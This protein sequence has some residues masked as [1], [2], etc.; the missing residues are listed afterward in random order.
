[1]AAL[2][3]TLVRKLRSGSRKQSFPIANAVTLY[4]G[5][6]VAIN[7]SGYVT[8]YAGA[9]IDTSRAA[10]IVGFVQPHP[11]PADLDQSLKGDTALTPVP[12]ATVETA[13]HILEQVA[14]TGVTAQSDVGKLV[15]LNSN[16]NDLTLTR[17]QNALALGVIDRWH[18]STTSDV[19][20]FSYET[21]LAL[22]KGMEAGGLQYSNTADSAAVTNTTTETAF[23]KSVTLA[24]VQLATGDV[25]EIVCMGVATATNST[26]TLNVKLKV[27]TEIVASTG[28][29]DVANDDIFYLHA[30]V[31]VQASGASGAL[32]A[33]GVRAIGADNTVT[34]KP[35][36]TDQASED[37]SGNVLVSATATWSVA[38]AGNSCKLEIL[39]VI[40]HRTAI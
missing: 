1:M 2:T 5:S 13:E 34:A 10:V 9:A 19:R 33:T 27:G 12:E 36:R 29:V 14:V 39:D 38:N 32:M 17:P 11:Y 35:F 3:A 6:Y 40:K 7:T 16:D 4:Q 30:F 28:A 37:L 21:R 23:D 25:L 26:D 20:V 18:T 8:T 24:G 22:A 15:Y 31:T